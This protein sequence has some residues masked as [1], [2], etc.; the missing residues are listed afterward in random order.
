MNIVLINN[1]DSF[2]YNFINYICQLVPNSNIFVEDNNILVDKLK[3]LLF[4]IF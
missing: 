1:Y 3:K 4:Y 2:V